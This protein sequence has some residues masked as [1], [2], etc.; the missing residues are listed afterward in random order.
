MKFAVRFAGETHGT[1]LGQGRRAG[2]GWGQRGQLSAG[3]HMGGQA[4][5]KVGGRGSKGGRHSSAPTGWG[6]L[7]VLY[8]LATRPAAA[9]SSAMIGGGEPRLARRAGLPFQRCSI[10]LS[11]ALHTV[12]DFDTSFQKILKGC[13]E[14]AE[15]AKRP[16]PGVQSNGALQGGGSGKVRSW[17]PLAGRPKRGAPPCGLLETS[18][19]LAGCSADAGLLTRLWVLLWWRWAGVWFGRSAWQSCRP[20]AVASTGPWRVGG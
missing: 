7:P 20:A 5:G 8:T 1:E 9:P 3:R 4:G 11:P 2:R 10:T 14:R 17:C 15:A 18:V 13:E 19:P 16:L 6:F 12:Q